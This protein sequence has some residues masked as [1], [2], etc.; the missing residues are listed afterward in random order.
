MARNDRE[1]IIDGVHCLAFFSIGC[2]ADAHT[3]VGQ[4][5]AAR[6]VAWRITAVAPDLQVVEKLG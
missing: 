5:Q 1:Q 3:V 6:S 2:D 4:V